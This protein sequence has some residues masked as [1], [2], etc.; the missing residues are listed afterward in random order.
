[1]IGL[2]LLLRMTRVSYAQ[3]T[4]FASLPRAQ[5]LSS[6]NHHFGGS[7]ARGRH[8][9]AQS[10]FDVRLRGG[11]TGRGLVAEWR[12]DEANAFGVATRVLD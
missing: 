2:Q 5:G 8:A 3:D 4:A 6:T 11:N 10:C 9:G 12:E 7:S 1:M